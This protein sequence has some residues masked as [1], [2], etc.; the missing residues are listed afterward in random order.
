MNVDEAKAL[1]KQWMDG[2]TIQFRYKTSD[3]EWFDYPTLEKI[4]SLPYTDKPTFLSS[5]VDYR[6]KPKMKQLTYRLGL[7]RDNKVRAFMF[8][9]RTLESAYDSDSNSLRRWIDSKWTTIEVEV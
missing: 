8:E 6:V 1:L 7:T 2:E 4:I 5:E 9:E 3:G